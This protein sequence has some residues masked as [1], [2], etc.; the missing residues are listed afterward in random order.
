[1]F[2]LEKDLRERTI[3]QDHGITLIIGAGLMKGKLSDA[4]KLM[5]D[6]YFEALEKANKST[7]ILVD[8][9]DR[10][11]LLKIE[12]WYQSMNTS[13][14]IWIGTGLENQNVFNVKSVSM[15]ERK[16]NFEGLAFLIEDTN[17]T[18][19]KTVMDGEE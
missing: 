19:I 8:V 3:Q 15:E 17:Y 18:V 13:H 7:V 1:M 5:I 10:M 4:G 16:L 12:N 9:Y 2:A 11:K 14:G 6:Q